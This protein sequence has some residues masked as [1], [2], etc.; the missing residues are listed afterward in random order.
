MDNDTNTAYIVEKDDL[1]DC[2]L[3]DVVVT[4]HG[5]HQLVWPAPNPTGSQTLDP[6]QAIGLTKL[7]DSAQ[8]GMPNP[9][10]IITVGGTTTFS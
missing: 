2:I 6:L 9:F 8:G 10:V 7:L 3:Y 1:S 4:V 5:L